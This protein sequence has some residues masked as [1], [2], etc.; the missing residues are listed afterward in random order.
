MQLAPEEQEITIKVL[1]NYF[2]GYA[3]R[4]LYLNLSSIEN[5]YGGEPI[6]IFKRIDEIDSATYGS[7]YE[8]YGEISRLVNS[9]HCS[10]TFFAIPCMYAFDYYLPIYFYIE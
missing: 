4:D 3:F 8:F 10:H 2:H 9:L 5:S 7:T 6:D 1:K